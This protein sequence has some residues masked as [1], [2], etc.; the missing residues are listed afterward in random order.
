[1]AFN[2]RL[3]D[4]IRETLSRHYGVIDRKMFG[5][6]AFMLRGNMC[7]GVVGNELMV[8]VLPERYGEALGRPH[9]RPMDFTG[10]PLKGMIYVGS[11][12]IATD[13]ALERW[14]KEG[15]DLVMSL[16]DKT[17]KAPMAA[18]K[19]VARKPVAARK[20]VVAKKSVAAKKPVAATKPE[21]ARKPVA[22]KKPVAAK[23]LRQAR[24]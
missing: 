23:K 22:V 14:V 12:G 4:R 2:E 19:S 18:K 6:I 21:A 3:A 17:T 9:A 8:R 10:K 20:P 7:C 5:G 1:M 24:G 11:K 15:V 16:P 13:A